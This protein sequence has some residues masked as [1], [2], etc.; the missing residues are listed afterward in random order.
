MREGVGKW[1]RGL[2]V[3]V[4]VSR[5]GRRGGVLRLG[6]VHPYTSEPTG[7]L[8]PVEVVPS[9]LREGVGENPSQLWPW[10]Q[11]CIVQSQ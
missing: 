7:T 6:G 1:W 10:F 2:R 11:T 9:R 4:E 3:A 8:V 5:D